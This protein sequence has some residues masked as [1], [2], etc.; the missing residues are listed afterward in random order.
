MQ[1]YD[2]YFRLLPIKKSESNSSVRPRTFV[3]MYSEINMDI[4]QDDTVPDV[5]KCR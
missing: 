3:Q 1:H 2:L 5:K 4:L